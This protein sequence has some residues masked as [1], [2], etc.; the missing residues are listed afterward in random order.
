MIWVLSFIKQFLFWIFFFLLN[1]LVFMAYH[2][3]K[4]SGIRFSET[5][6]T[7]YQAIYLDVSTACYL[8]ILPFFLSIFQSLK[9]QRFFAAIN[10]LYSWIIIVVVSVL[11][12]SE[13]GVY[14]E[15]GTKLNAK[16]LM[17]LE[18][19]SEI[20]RSATWGMIISG[21]FFILLQSVAGIYLYRKFIHSQPDSI[22]MASFS[23]QY[24]LTSLLLPG[25]IFLGLRGGWQPIPI[26]QSD[27][28]F[29]KHNILND[30]AVNSSWNLLQSIFQNRRNMNKNPYQF[31]TSEEA[32]KVV[33]ELYL[34]AKDTTEKIIYAGERGNVS[35]P[36][37]VLIILEGWTA[38]V[39]E[40]LGGE[41]GVAPEFEKLI[42][43]G[44]LFTQCYS[45]GE[46]SEQGMAAILSGFPAQAS[47]S[48]INEPSKYPQLPSVNN[49]F[50]EAGYA[51]SYMFGGQLNYG[52][53]KGYIYY[54]RFGKI[55][56]GNDFPDHI[57]TQRLGVP[58]QY[59]YERNINELENEK[60]PFFS[61]MYTLS[62]HAPYD[63]PME[64]VIQTGGEHKKYLNSVYY[65][66]RSLGEYF[67][68]AQTKPWYKN[69]LF[70]IISDHSHPSPANRD[71]YEPAN[72]KIPLLI[73]GDLLK[74]EYRGKKTEKVI[75]QVDVPATL[76]GQL[77]LKHDEFHWSKDFFNPYTRG[78]AYY[79]FF[80]DGFGWVEQDAAL[81]YRYDINSIYR[82]TT[83]SQDQKSDFERKGK[84]FIQTAFREY[85]GD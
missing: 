30:A 37:V 78:F 4:L 23:A 80:T 61:V 17:Y 8:L 11:V 55:I 68:N 22:P 28:Y 79:T 38:D 35:K 65:A 14:D 53:I 47:N 52:N 71:F 70:L 33:K 41:K 57:P 18:H 75:S 40:S 24:I 81:V 66:D 82:N 72:K 27:V 2:F 15:W 49:R 45:S 58:D 3:D 31:Y 63:Q 73:Y 42:E 54:S 62:S 83:T 84:A 9:W 36:N 44:L 77:G 60:Q 21:G 1:R 32:D 85:L 46:R 50:L 67:R 29:S 43:G 69:T 26:H 20:F 6:A 39:I 64:D 25:F 16:A 19:P 74:K 7:F 59:L 34:V 12:S 76:L 48:I 13:L 51:T 56:E 10:N 5:I